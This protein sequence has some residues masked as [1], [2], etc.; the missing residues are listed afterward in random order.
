MKITERLSHAWNALQGR[1]DYSVNTVGSS[2]RPQYNGA[3][4][5]PWNET[6]LTD[7]IYNRIAVDCSMV[8]LRHVLV[9]KKTNKMQK[10]DSSLIECLRTEANI[11]QSGKAFVHDL[12][13]SLLD[14][15]CVAIVPTV[16]TDSPIKTGSYDVNQMRVGKITQWYA[17]SVTIKLYNDSIGQQQDITL[18]KRMVAIIQNPF[19]SI[20]SG[21]N[22]LLKRITNKMAQIDNL[23]ELISSGA[24]NLIIQ[25]PHPVKTEKAKETAESRVKDIKDQLTDNRYGVAYI[26]TSE[27]FTQLNRPVES[28]L[29]T[30]IEYLTKQLYAALGLTE[31]V[32]N[33]TAGESEMLAYFSRTIDPLITMML[34]EISRKFLTKTARTQGQRLV[35]YRNPFKLVPVEQ[36]SNIIDTFTRDKIITG[37]EGREAVGYEPVDDPTADVLSNPSIA[38]TNS[39]PLPDTS[40]KQPESTPDNSSSSGITNTGQ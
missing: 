26:D 7:I 1:T 11:D 30:E 31:N 22:S 13:Y 28:D 21:Q 12:I 25:L 9:D 14:E 5:S 32:M 27:K 33:G 29:Q 35:Y 17:D 15:G 24:L 40:I 6:T 3:F 4:S 39:N 19:R 20:T 2:V 23:D 10:Y 8:D 37:N 16:T 34:D 38:D 18:P 36:L